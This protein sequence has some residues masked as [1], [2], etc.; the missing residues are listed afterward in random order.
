MSSL[1]GTIPALLT[2]FTD[3]GAEVDFDLLDAHLGWLHERGVRTVS[4]MG[5]TG[6]GASLSLAERKL[7]IACIAA[8]PSGI[9]MLAGTGCTNLPETIELS[10]FAVERGTAGLLVAPPSYYEA[11]PEGTTEYYVRLLE[12]LP[13]EARVF[14][15]H[16]PSQTGVPIEDETLLAL[17]ERFGP[18]VA[19]AKDSSGDLDHVRRWLRDYRHLTI[20]SGS[21]GF[22]SAVYASGGRGTITLL[23]NVFPEELEA[24]RRGD[25]VDER[26]AFLTAARAL[27]GELPRHAA[28]KHLLHLVSGLPRTSVRPPLQDLD[29][30]QMAYLETR[31]SDLR[32]EAHV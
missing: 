8:H 3:G 30:E 23:A 6:E 25:R 13:R 5:T 27:V 24:I 26:Q 32:S 15:Y 11:T 9:V 19:G 20:L 18:V 17:E 1:G 10:R 22:V 12:A 14:A 7:V 2:P 31:F 29:E 4:P 16:I 28:L 21:D